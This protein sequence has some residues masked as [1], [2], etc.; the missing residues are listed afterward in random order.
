[1]CGLAFALFRRIS[2][3]RQLRR[4]AASGNCFVA[5]SAVGL[6]FGGGSLC[7]ASQPRDAGCCCCRRR[8]SPAAGSSVM[9][10]WA[11][12][13][14]DL[15]RNRYRGS[16]IALVRATARCPFGAQS[17]HS[18]PRAAAAASVLTG[19][20]GSSEGDLVTYV[21]WLVEENLSRAA[22]RGATQAP[23]TSGY[24]TAW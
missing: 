18:W 6:P 12:G 2:R 9:P 19:S 11:R 15:A 20:T 1:M 7:G 10:A 16:S 13:R 8:R 4:L 17:T 3:C 21:R 5:D 22:G 24:P 23:P 14:C